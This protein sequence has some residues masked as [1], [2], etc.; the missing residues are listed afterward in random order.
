MQEGQ[1]QAGGLGIS[2][3]LHLTAQMRK[4]SITAKELL[5]QW[6]ESNGQ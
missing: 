3:K 5:F 4:K 2:Q 6:V 1:R